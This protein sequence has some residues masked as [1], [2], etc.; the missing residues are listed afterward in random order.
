M[1]NYRYTMD[2][3][4]TK[5]DF[6]EK[7]LWKKE[8]LLKIREVIPQ[9]EPL[10]ESLLRAIRTMFLEDSKYNNPDHGLE[11]SKVR[12]QRLQEWYVNES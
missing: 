5:E 1:E 2:Q 4:P 11:S 10:G 3:R 12:E 9:N 8:A 7:E 6:D